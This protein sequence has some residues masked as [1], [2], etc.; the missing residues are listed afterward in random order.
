MDTAQD[1]LLCV[2][3]DARDFSGASMSSEF[4]SNSCC[5]SGASSLTS[6]DLGRIL[7]EE[8]FSSGQS[9]SGDKMYVVRT[10]T[11]KKK[12][13]KKRADVEEGRSFTLVVDEVRKKKKSRSDEVWTED[14]TS[15]SGGGGFSRWRKDSYSRRE[16]KEEAEAEEDIFQDFVSMVAREER[17][18]E[19]GVEIN[20]AFW[21]ICLGEEGERER[22]R[23]SRVLESLHI[24]DRPDIFADRCELLEGR[25]RLNRRRNDKDLG[26]DDFFS[27]WR[28]NLQE[29]RGGRGKGK[30]RR[31]GR[32]SRAPTAKREGQQQQEEEVKIFKK[33]RRS[34]RNNKEKKNKADFASLFNLEDDGKK[35]EACPVVGRRRSRDEVEDEEVMIKENSPKRFKP[36]Q[37]QH[38]QRGSFELITG[39]I[40]QKI[41]EAFAAAEYEE[42]EEEDDDD[43][44]AEELSWSDRLAESSEEFSSLRDE[45]RRLRKSVRARADSEAE[46][47]AFKEWRWNLENNAD[48][49]EEEEAEDVF[50]EW[51]HN[52]D[53]GDLVQSPRSPAVKIGSKSLVVQGPAVAMKKKTGSQDKPRPEKKGESRRASA[54]LKERRRLGRCRGQLSQPRQ[55]MGGK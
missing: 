37:H 51:R 32:R 34:G 41:R 2:A 3:N 52:F 17:R 35:D 29:K 1:L 44:D 49:E 33:R 53:Q 11:E 43:V 10:K 16:W 30:R 9:S 20:D 45:V 27:D 26:A 13:N 21:N 25:T 14:E 7:E 40:E 8:L 39:A 48:K 18:K 24:G 55:R 12:K 46:V 5:S 6:Q 36:E 19:D 15:L 22:R 54:A 4:S 28:G 38:Q 42:L 50:G 47:V 23:L 31:R